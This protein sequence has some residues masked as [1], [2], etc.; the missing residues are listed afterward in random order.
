VPSSFSS[1]ALTDGPPADL[2]PRR[3]SRL[4]AFAAAAVCALV[5]AAVCSNALHETL[6]RDDALV[7]RQD[8]RV[9][10]GDWVALALG[11][12]W[13]EDF[14]FADRLYRPLVMLSFAAQRES[15]PVGLRLVNIALHAAVCAAVCYWAMRQWNSAAAG[16]AA[17]L[18]FA[19][20]PVHTE[21]L[22][23]VV[24][25][26]DVAATLFAVV[27][28]VAIRRRPVLAGLSFGAALLCK[29]QP[30]LLPTVVF[31]FDRRGAAILCVVVALYLG[32]RLVAIGSLA[33]DPA[34]IAIADNVI[35]H[36]SHDA[37]H[38][39][40][41]FLAR[42]GTP[43]AVFGQAAALIFCPYPLCSDYSYA[44]IDL[45]R[46]PLE[47][48]FLWGVFSLAAVISLV[49]VGRQRPWGLGAA[50]ALATY[51]VVSNGPVVI[52]TIFGERLLYLPS[53]GVC[54]AFGG[55]AMGVHRWKAGFVVAALVLAGAAASLARNP[56][57]RSME[58]LVRAD[59]PKRPQSCRLL[60]QSAAHELNEGRPEA[61]ME[62]CRR[63]TAVC[64]TYTAIDIVAGLAL[65][66]LGRDREALETFQR[67]F[68]HGG[69]I[70]EPAVVAAAELLVKFGDVPQAIRILQTQLARFPAWGQART[71]MSELQSGKRAA[72]NE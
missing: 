13:N 61:A 48:R 14:R 71:L 21:A 60:T 52:G 50:W 57:W 30:I 27:A 36:P 62:Y 6:L 7:L 69:E 2:P 32:L 63:A 33:R 9:F 22:N 37:P 44:A 68:Q 12:Y 39:A 56:D 28:I 25:R 46:S 20:H 55:V 26:A 1:R 66:R 47:P 51:A 72:A 8:E 67:S 5:G 45:V 53:A 31:L 17:G 3:D 38:G 58:S 19:V 11:G 43:I 42:W 54:M 24:G 23:T 40:S 34:S 10:R 29:E 70:S 64:P 15:A 65:H 35:A 18:L 16:L 49:V 59:L 4:G 41:E